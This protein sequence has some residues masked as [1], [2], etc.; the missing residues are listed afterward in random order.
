MMVFISNRKTT[1]F[2]LQ[3]QSSG[4]DNFLAKRVL[5]NSSGFDNFLA[6]GFVYNSYSKKVVKTF[7]AI[8]VIYNSYS[9]KAVKT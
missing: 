1:C 9:K 3:R 2:V 8:R 5:Y 4:F 7:L 6:I